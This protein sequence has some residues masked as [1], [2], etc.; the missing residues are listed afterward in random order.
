MKFL[1]DTHTLIWFIEG[2]SSLSKKARQ[3]I[4]DPDNE[5][6]VSIVTFFEMS[7]KHKLNKLSLSK[8][9][10]DFYYT[11]LNENIDILAIKEQHIFSYQAIP[12]I[13]GR[14]EKGQELEIL[15]GKGID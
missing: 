13:D 14:P 8:S 9:L 15:G 7:I 3:I 11:T 2:S 6:Y 1:L 10:S 12:L 4:E 5:M